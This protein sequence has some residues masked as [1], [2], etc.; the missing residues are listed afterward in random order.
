M[1]QLLILSDIH[2]NISALKRVLEDVDT[3][4]S[5]EAA[6]ILGDSIDYG[7]CSNEVCGI[8]ESFKIPVIA[9]L[10]G[11]H[12]YAVMMEDYNHFSSQ[13]GID[14]AKHTRKTISEKSREYL[15][16]VAGKK[17]MMEFEYFGK[18][19]LAVH[20]SLENTYWKSITVGGNFH[21]YAKYDYVLSGHSHIP[22]YFPVFF[23]TADSV[24]RN[25]KR[26]VFINPGSVGQPRNHD[27]HAQYAVLDF[28]NGVMM[29]SVEYDIRFE[30]SLFTD[31]VD[32]FY[33][34]RLERGV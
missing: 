7:M 13:R 18:S 12:E 25:K 19:F 4:F 21:G 24:M 6:V 5:P 31:E 32:R 17:G 26:T 27:S 11:N 9:T 30:Q 34:D 14:S 10:W 1:Q 3:T 8:L 2:G 22:H 23:E 20:G 16:T 29:R 28:Q 15:N 33:R